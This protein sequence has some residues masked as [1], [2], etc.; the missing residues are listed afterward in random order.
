[1]YNFLVKCRAFQF[2]QCCRKV[3]VIGEKLYI[4]RS[5]DFFIRLYHEKNCSLMEMKKF[6]YDR[7]I[8]RFIY[9]YIYISIISRHACM[10]D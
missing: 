6:D 7:S 1:M 10:R 4:H 5:H 8:N 9:N 2:S 3:L